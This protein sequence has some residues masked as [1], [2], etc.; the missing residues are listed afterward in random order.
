MVF[1]NR[2]CGENTNSI[3]TCRWRPVFVTVATEHVLVHSDYCDC[4]PFVATEGMECAR[5][6]VLLWSPVAHLPF[7]PRNLNRSKEFHQSF[8][9]LWVDA[10]DHWLHVY[11]WM[12]RGYKRQFPFNEYDK[13]LIPVI[14]YLIMSFKLSSV[15]L[16][17]P[18]QKYWVKSPPLGTQLYKPKS[19]L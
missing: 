10:E 9:I 17:K 4:W 13:Y 19:R 8:V 12:L 14:R 16:W 5:T 6:E 3:F 7:F 11:R 15:W 2:V 18:G 1:E